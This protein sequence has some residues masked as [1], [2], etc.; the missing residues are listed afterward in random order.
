M[1]RYVYP[2]EASGGRQRTARRSSV[3][4][5]ECHAQGWP[6][7]R[8]PRTS[9]SANSAD[10]SHHRPEPASLFISLRANV[11]RARVRCR[12]RLETSRMPYGTMQISPEQGQLMGL[13]VRLVGARRALE[14]GTFT[15]YSALAFALAL[16]PDGTLICCDISEGWTQTAQRYWREAGVANRIELRLAPSTMMRLRAPMFSGH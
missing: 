11:A 7:P 4:Q 16:P 1:R 6:S 9:A 10:Q 14:I 13:L 5:G 3:N 15:G 8:T 12:L 2:V